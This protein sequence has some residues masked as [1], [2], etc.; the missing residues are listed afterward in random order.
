VL[1]PGALEHPCEHVTGCSGFVM[2]AD[3]MAGTAFLDQ[4]GLAA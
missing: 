1:E 2:G 4:S 3:D